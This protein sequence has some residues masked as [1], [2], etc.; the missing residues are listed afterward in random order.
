MSFF[1]RH[2]SLAFN[3]GLV[4]L[5]LAAAVG[6]Q[7]VLGPATVSAAKDEVC[8]CHAT[9]RAPSTHFV[10]VCANRTAIY[11]QAGHFNEDGTPQAGHEEDYEGPCT[12]SDP[13]PTPDP[14]P[15]IK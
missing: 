1:R 15:G 8:I 3:L 9:G 11:G 5:A 6:L 10:T 13:S 4:A 2:K 7:I 12:G 14:S